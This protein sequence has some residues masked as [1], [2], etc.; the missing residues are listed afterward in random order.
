M[1]FYVT[2]ACI[3]CGLCTTLDPETFTMTEAGVAEVFTQPAEAAL[4]LADLLTE[5]GADVTTCDLT[6]TH[7]SDALTQAFCCGKLVLASVTYDGGLF[8]PME[9]LLNHLK[10]KNFQ[11]RKIGLMENGSWAPQAARLMRARLEEMKNLTLCPT[12]VS[13][14]SALNEGSRQQLE[15][16]ADELLTP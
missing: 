4:A 14:R 13:I 15:Q 2:D 7:V 1:E 6:T 16:L 11:S 5:R 10:A 12:A 9:E 3:G 8:P